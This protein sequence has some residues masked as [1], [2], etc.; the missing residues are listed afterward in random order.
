[1]KFEQWIQRELWEHPDLTFTVCMTLSC[2]V[3]ILKPQFLL[4]FKDQKKIPILQG[5]CEDY[6][7]LYMLNT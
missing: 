6:L 1:M 7:R 3:K 4:F 2:L 5:C